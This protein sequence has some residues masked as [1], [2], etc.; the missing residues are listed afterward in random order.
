[1]MRRATPCLRALPDPQD[2]MHPWE[3][4]ARGYPR[5]WRAHARGLLHLSALSESTQ[6][7]QARGNTRAMQESF[8]HECDQCS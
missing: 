7:G 2:D 5:Q 4:M 1:M 6:Y 8:L 3:E